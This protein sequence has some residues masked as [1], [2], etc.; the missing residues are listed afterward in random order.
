[1]DPFI[2]LSSTPE[3]ARLNIQSEA[4]GITRVEE[5]DL[6][7]WNELYGA[8]SLR[9]NQ[10]RAT[11]EIDNTLPSSEPNL[12]NF[13]GHVVDQH[14]AP[15]AGAKI[16]FAWRNLRRGKVS[17]VDIQTAGDGRIKLIGASG[18]LL[19]VFVSKE[20]YVP[21]QT[22]ASSS[23]EYAGPSGKRFTPDPRKPVRLVLGK[24]RLSTLLPLITKA[25]PVPKTGELFGFDPETYVYTTNGPFFF[26]CSVGALDDQQQAEVKFQIAVRN[27]GLIETVD[28]IPWDAPEGGYRPEITRFYPKHWDWIHPSIETRAYFHLT[29]PD[30]WGFLRA[31]VNDERTSRL[32]TPGP[33]LVE[34]SFVMT[35]NVARQLDHG[36]SSANISYLVTEAPE[37]GRVRER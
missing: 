9:D 35:T 21:S 27:G 10:R 12:I 17:S 2:A 28:E 31:V 22:A 18:S 19:V 13:W 6:R 20:G 30:R 16:H 8:E 23:Y 36:L 4:R 26:R 11:G 29:Q 37:N 32:A 33:A 7:L 5:S 15:V 14:G 34:M 3:E 24:P 25:V 1:M